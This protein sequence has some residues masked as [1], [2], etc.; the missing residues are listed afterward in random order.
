[1][2]RMTVGEMVVSKSDGA[3]LDVLIVG[4]GMSGLLAA[5]RLKQ[6]GL[7]KLQILEKSEGLGG[8]WWSN[9]Y[10]GCA[11]DI[12]SHFY[13]YSFAPNPDWTRA[14][15]QQSEILTYF[16]RVA[17]SYG[18]RPLIRFGAEV[19]GAAYDE[20]AG[21]W[22][23]T[24]ADG[25]ALSARILILA[26][27]QLSRPA[28]PRIEGA[29]LFEGAAFH[30]AQWDE[31]MDLTGK[32]VAV[33]GNGPSSAQ[34][35][36]AIAP[37]VAKLV[38]FQRT[39]NWFYPRGDRPY[40]PLERFLFRHLPG[41]ARMH[42]AFIYLQRESLY[43]GFRQGSFAARFLDRTVR[44]ILERQ[45]ADPK[46]RERLTPDYPPGCK[47]IIVSDDFLPTLQRENVTL[48]TDAIARITPRGIVTAG[49]TSHEVDV[50]VYGTGFRSTEFVA[51]IEITGAAGASL[52]Q[53]WEG[54]A[55]AYC[56]TTVA[57]FPNMFI[58]YGPNTNLGHNSIIFMVEQ[59]VAHMMRLVE[60]LFRRGL[61]SVA[62]R[63]AAMKAY[64]ERLQADLGGS[65]WK[66]G[67]RN[68]YMTERG[69]ITNNWPHSTIAWRR[70][71]RRIDLD[72]FELVAAG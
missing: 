49:G 72:D 14:Y 10:P 51:P 61:R 45:V 34:I 17:D 68:W 11:C 18:L 2:T 13:S 23:V 5:I 50:I 29:E 67:C 46:L 19:A 70:R 30:S 64:N 22:T 48:E 1:M 15:P 42:R 66:T 40:G 52:S 32:R 12:P 54:G 63:P 24:M 35:V 57:G 53:R 28:I 7:G 56:G 47:R 37:D 38:V 8:T 3:V 26:T 27:G 55:E 62:V 58:L 33:I 31:N 4:A 71:T 59:Q 65:V 9:R 36:P 16:G 60:T 25:A 20:A 39:P 43:A 69:K 44:K 41:Y 6:A 21:C